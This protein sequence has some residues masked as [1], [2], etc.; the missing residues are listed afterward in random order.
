MNRF[1]NHIVVPVGVEPTT[2]R[3]HFLEG[4]R[5]TTALRDLLDPYAP[6]D[7]KGPCGLRRPTGSL[8]TKRCKGTFGLRRPFV[9]H[10]GLDPTTVT[11]PS[12][13]DRIRVTLYQGELMDHVHNWTRGHLPH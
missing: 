1:H 2:F 3:F 12:I 8:R 5:A 7:A 10:V 9:V 6:K 4:R 13:R 11:Y